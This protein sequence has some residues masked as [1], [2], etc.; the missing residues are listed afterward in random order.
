MPSLY[1]KSNKI[2]PYIDKKEKNTSFSSK[3]YTILKYSFVTMT[4]HSMAYFMIK[5]FIAD[6]HYRNLINDDTSILQ[7]FTLSLQIPLFL[8]P[9]IMIT[10]DAIELFFEGIGNYINYI[11]GNSRPEQQYLNKLIMNQ[12]KPYSRLI[13]GNVAMSDQ[14]AS[15]TYI[16]LH[17]NLDHINDT[18]FDKKLPLFHENKELRHSVKTEC[19][20]LIEEYL[21]Q[22]NATNDT[23][24]T[25]D[26]STAKT[27]KLYKGFPICVDEKSFKERFKTEI[28]TWVNKYIE[29]KQATINQSLPC[30]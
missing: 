6:Y 16:T 4:I 12:Y 22:Y 8:A 2:P 17:D 10:L 15:L 28:D 7:R 26:T 11:S 29:S 24:D 13:N 30:N 20:T 18:L 1:K 23:E 25:K 19:G 21:A 27:K 14:L 5:E 9:L 3:A